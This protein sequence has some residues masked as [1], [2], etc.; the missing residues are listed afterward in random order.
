MAAEFRLLQ[1]RLHLAQRQG[2][3]ER[4][5][6]RLLNERRP[7]ALNVGSISTADGSA[8]V[9]MGCT[10]V[11]CGVKAE[12][13]E[14]AVTSPKQGYIVPNVD[15][16]PLCSPMFK[17]GPPGEQAQVLS[18]LMLDILTSSDSLDLEKLCI[19]EGKLVWSLNVDLTCLDYDGNVAEACIL[20]ATAAL[21]S[22][23]LP[24]VLTTD[25]EVNVLLE[26][27]KAKVTD[28]PLAATFAVL[29]DDTIVVDPTHEEECLAAETFTVVLNADDK[30]CGVHKPGGSALSTEQISEHVE[31]ARKL[32]EDS[33]SLLSTA[34]SSVT[35]CTA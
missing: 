18:K 9:K 21:C 8:L 10:T 13:A 26:R 16:L 29:A 28:G 7:T 33:R 22:L 34:M 4:S 20:A 5:D 15:L 27:E 3:Y 1:S 32:V 17:P 12:L 2:P 14:P 35:Q 24:K 30:I 11:V 31:L 19:E 6:G 25:G 23:T